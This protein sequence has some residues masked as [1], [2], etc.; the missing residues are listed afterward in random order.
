MILELNHV[1][2]RFGG[3]T[4]ISDMSMR[5]PEHSIKA[6]IGPNG[7]GK[8]TAFNLITGV[9][10]VTE[11]SILFEG[12]EI[13]NTRPDKVVEMGICRTFQNIRLF[14]KMTAL[15]NVATGM[16]CRSKND[17]MSVVFRPLFTR[18]EEKEIYEKSMELLK[19]FRLDG[20]AKEMANN[21]AYGHQRI[22]EIARA[23][24]SQPKLLLLDEP[25]AGMNREEKVALVD[26][27]RRIRD[28]FHLTILLVEHDMSLVM[29]LAEDITV[30]NFGTVIANGTP[31]EIQK[32]EQVIEAYLGRDD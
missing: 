10:D 8:T 31:E 30:L 20:Y 27:I 15:D 13:S 1:T 28:D 11:G 26:L 14:K 16:H 25:A 32:N 23:L 22:L 19:Y 6:L 3:L 7:A 12:R 21:L 17:L 4:A 24:A 2:K 18:T 29:S 9:Y 5:V